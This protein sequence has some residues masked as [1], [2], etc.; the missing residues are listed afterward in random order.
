[1][2]GEGFLFAKLPACHQM[3]QLQYWIMYRKGVAFTP[4]EKSK[5]CISPS[6][7][8]ERLSTVILH[9]R[10]DTHGAK[11]QNMDR[12]G[13]S[14][15]QKDRSSSDRDVQESSGELDLRQS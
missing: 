12:H 2:A 10:R 15:A 14:K 8:L 13:E 4:E 9:T 5:N 1:M 11:Y 6:W 7:S 3:P